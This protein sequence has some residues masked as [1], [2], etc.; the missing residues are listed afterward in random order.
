MERISM[1]SKF[2]ATMLVLAAGLMVVPA[3]ATVY[4]YTNNS[5]KPVMQDYSTSWNTDTE[6]LSL[7]S[8]WN[9]SAGTIDRIDFLISDGGSPW[10]TVHNGVKTEQ[11]LFYSLN[12]SS[13]VVSVNE[14]FG[15]KAIASFSGL[16]DITANSFSLDFDTN[17]LGLDANSF[18]P[19]AY[20][21]AGYTDEVGIWHYL[22][23]GGTRVETLDIHNGQTV[24]TVPEPT[25][26]ALLG[27]GLLG[28]A[29][30]KKL[31]NK[32]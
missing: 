25:S 17:M 18:S 29:G 8:S 10:K 7:A 3:H 26:M 28:L 20:N 24:A 32:N 9:N 6:V 21:G 31:I 14:Y 15:R 11:F 19:L 1:K 12:L 13:N 16:M 5:P 27:L 2:I 23:S 30:R 4:T 22:Y